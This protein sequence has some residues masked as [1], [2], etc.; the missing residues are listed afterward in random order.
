MKG[1]LVVCSGRLRPPVLTRTGVS[2]HSPPV[3]A[4]ACSGCCFGG[5]IMKVT[6][7]P[8]WRLS[9]KKLIFHG[10]QSSHL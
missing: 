3:V 2:L 7:L 8:P 9:K 6:G 5:K 4:P 10:A 1:L